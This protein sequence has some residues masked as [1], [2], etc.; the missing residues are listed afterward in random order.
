MRVEEVAVGTSALAVI[1]GSYAG[2]KAKLF[3]Q[4][5]EGVVSVAQSR[6]KVDLPR[7]APAGTFIAPKL[8]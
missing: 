1:V 7:V 2:C 3:T 8:E 4:N 6:V 5:L